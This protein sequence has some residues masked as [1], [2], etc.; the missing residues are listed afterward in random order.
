MKNDIE[1]SK[2]IQSATG[3]AKEYIKIC[4]VSNLGLEPI[5][6]CLLKE[7]FLEHDINV[8]VSFI[9]HERLY[10]SENVNLL[11]KLITY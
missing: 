8:E 5:F 1:M 9:A 6:T 7:S 2:Y 11:G 10:E 3:A 4:V